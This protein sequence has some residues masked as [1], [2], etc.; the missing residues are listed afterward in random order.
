MESCVRRFGMLSQDGNRT[1]KLHIFP[2]QYAPFFP[3]VHPMKP[4]FESSWQRLW[5][6][7]VILLLLWAIIYYA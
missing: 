1:G 4:F 5:Q 7:A 3:I 2:L 6:A